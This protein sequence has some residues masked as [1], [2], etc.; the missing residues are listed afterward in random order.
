MTYQNDGR[1]YVYDAQTMTAYAMNSEEQAF[2]W[3][4][5]WLPR[6]DVA[7]G[8]FPGYTFLN[9]S[10]HTVAELRLLTPGHADRAPCAS[11]GATLQ[12]CCDSGAW[13][14][15]RT[16]DTLHE[17]PRC[18]D[19]CGKCEGA[20]EALSAWGPEDTLPPLPTVREGSSVCGGCDGSDPDCYCRREPSGSCDH[21]GGT[22]YW[23]G[24]CADTA[25]RYDD[26]V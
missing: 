9:P 11:C 4:L 5:R 2:R 26:W 25:P 18:G 19:C 12:V 21:K 20:S 22:S 7:L 1:T 13:A 16:G 3:R 15:A 17:N 23:C 10:R 8:R 6:A 24:Y 14:D